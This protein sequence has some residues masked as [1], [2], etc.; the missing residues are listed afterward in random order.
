MKQEQDAR[1]KGTTRKQK[2]FLIIKK[3]GL[4]DEIGAISQ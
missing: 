3:K 2:R 1:N 4:E